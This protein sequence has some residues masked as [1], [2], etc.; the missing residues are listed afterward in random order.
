M[1][2]GILDETVIKKIIN[3]ILID[4]S[5]VDNVFVEGTELSI[6]SN[7]INSLI[8]H[9]ENYGLHL[10]A[11]GENYMI[12]SEINEESAAVKASYAGANAAENAANVASDAAKEAIGKIN[13]KDE[14]ENEDS[15]KTNAQQEIE[16]KKE[17]MEIKDKGSSKTKEE[18]E[19][20]I[21]KI[22]QMYKVNPKQVEDS[23]ENSPFIKKMME[24]DFFA[25]L[26]G[27]GEEN[28]SDKE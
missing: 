1:K 8:Q 16:A 6:E 3:D 20:T 9:L 12:A 22:S 11:N 2:I 10:I 15:E 4:R 13:K 25:K 28:N 18:L 7:D 14:D 21:A 27:D 17:A 24:N 23:V 19:N 26:H 5:E